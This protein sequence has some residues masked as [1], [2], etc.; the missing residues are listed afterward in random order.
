[1]SSTI[2]S[3]IIMR[4]WEYGETDLIVSFFTEDRGWL[5]GIAK[6]GR[7]SRTRFANCLDLFCLCS[8][9]YEMKQGR[10][11]CFLQSGKLI[12]SFPGI[13]T[14][15]ASLSLASYMLEVM[16][17]LFPSETADRIAFE[18]FKDSLSA[19]D[20]GGDLTGLR[21]L[22][23]ARA[24][25]LGGYAIDFSRCCQCG[26]KYAGEG[27]AV[28]NCSKGGISCLRCRGESKSAPGLQP[29]MVALLKRLQFAPV[30][31]LQR[32]DWDA[33][34][35]DKIRAVLDLHMEYRIGRTLKSAK[36]L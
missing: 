1:M 24:M 14:N 25:A 7:K 21:M 20:N 34:G 5:K 12:H 27:T 22:F 15:F 3:S 10:D 19:M 11:L 32:L 35:N 31:E 36:Y 18:L 17:L 16:E 4:T 9:E 28:F 23:E 8:L 33:T 30:E 26:R 13:R 6:G 2:S 29:S